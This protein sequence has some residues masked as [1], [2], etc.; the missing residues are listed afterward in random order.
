MKTGF[1]HISQKKTL[2]EDDIIGIFDMD[3]STVSPDT[4]SFL[5]NSQKTGKLFSETDDIPK[6]FVL[7][8]PGNVYLSRLSPQTLGKRSD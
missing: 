3:T 4:R 8:F 7:T 1:L 6:S 2:P 5:R